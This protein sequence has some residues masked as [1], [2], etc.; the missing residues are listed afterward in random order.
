M[1]A[2]SCAQAAH[3]GAKRYGEAVYPKTTSAKSN[4]A[5]LRETISDWTDTVQI[6]ADLCRWAETPKGGPKAMETTT[7]KTA[8]K[9][10][11]QK[12][13]KMRSSTK[14]SIK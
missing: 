1:A 8:A 12:Y 2:P 6:V 3:T 5:I 13:F 11:L 14:T 10:R 4:F 7:P 9:M